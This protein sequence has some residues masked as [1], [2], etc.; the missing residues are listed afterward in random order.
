M[1]SIPICSVFRPEEQWF[2]EKDDN[3]DDTGN[4]LEDDLEYLKAVDFYYIELLDNGCYRWYV[5]CVSWPDYNNY[6]SI[7]ANG[8]DIGPC[9]YYYED[10]KNFSSWQLA[11][12]D[13]ADHLGFKYYL[14]SFGNI[15]R[16]HGISNFQLNC[17]PYFLNM[18]RESMEASRHE[19]Y[20]RSEFGEV[21]GGPI[22]LSF[23]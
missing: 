23:E 9:T 8:G 1:S 5:N 2:F 12:D 6:L 11:L 4:F 13:L 17:E 21:Y 18:V 15:R 20:K 3:G 16:L 19:N 22:N 7:S 14:E 10:S